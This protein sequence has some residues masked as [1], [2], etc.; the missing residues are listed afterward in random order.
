MATTNKPYLE[1]NTIF[2]TKFNSSL[3]SL[4]EGCKVKKP[5]YSP[6]ITKTTLTALF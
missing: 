6:I 3:F 2:K 4:P 1:I 5:G